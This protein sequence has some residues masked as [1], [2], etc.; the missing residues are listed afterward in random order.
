MPASTSPVPR[1]PAKAPS[2]P[3]PIANGLVYVNPDMPGIARLKHGERFR[4]R[5]AKGRWVRDVDELSRIRM[6]A[7][8]PAYTQVWICPLPNGHLQATG[9]DAR[10]RK[11]Y[12]YHA[13]WRVM[14]DETKFERLEAFALALP[15]IRA[16]VARD[17]QPEKGQKIPGRRQVLA[18]LVRLLD[19]T[20]LRVGNEEYANTNGSFGLTTLRNRHAAVQGTALRL[21]FK[22][23]SGVM[24]EAKLEDPRVAKVV[25]QCQQLPGQALFQYADEEGE[26][27]G[28]SSTDVNDYIAEAAEG[29]E[30]DRFTAKDFRTWHGTVQA[31]ELTRLAC[32]PGRVAVDGS[33][34]SA[35]DILAAVA[36]QLGNTPA[37]CKKAYVHPAV[38]ALGSALA[39]DDEDAATAL[40][41]KIAGRPTAKPSR[42]LYAAERRLLA[43]LRT[44]RQA[45]ARERR[46]EGR[47][48]RR[49]TAGAPRRPQPVASAKRTLS[50]S[51]A[52]A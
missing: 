3:T 51:S 46:A 27:R 23:K 13:D 50:P 4:Y 41:E 24:H 33:R 5:D 43:F 45:Q 48:N 19:T 38:L 49:P 17:L 2:K 32:E 26:L 36:K 39:K 21:R 44:H 16:R 25:R 12:R 31:L 52:M 29:I 14:K 42:G 10:G 11:Q 7:I 18:A 9:I 20:L 37:V 8:P 6:L 15:R 28:V 22:G 34:Y 40:F 47:A 35:K 1:P 30:G